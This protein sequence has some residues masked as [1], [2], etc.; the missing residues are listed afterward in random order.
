M[1]VALIGGAGF[2]GTRLAEVLEDAGTQFQ[3]LDKVLTGDR[4]I[5]ITD[6][7]TFKSKP[8]FDAVINLAAEHRDDVS[9]KSQYDLVNVEG[10][11]N[12][13]QFCRDRDIKTIVFTS[14]VAVYGFAPEG[15]KE[16]GEIN[17]FNDYGRTKYLAENVYRAWH[18]EDP[19]NRNLIIVRPTVIFGEGNR[20]NVYNLFNQI[21]SGRFL[22]FGN[23]RNR[24][25]MA[26]VQNVAEFL[27]FSTKMTGYHLYNYID[28]PNLDMNTLV[29]IVR[30]ILFG[31][32]E[33]G[34]RLP[35]WL[36]I[37]IG[38]TFDLVAVCLNRNLTVSSIR[39]KKFMG[40]TSFDSSIEITGFTSQITLEEGL[41][42]TL[43]Y[44]FIEDNSN[45][46]TFQSE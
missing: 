41:E 13:C 31:K 17:Y 8:A 6:P 21:A 12:I 27:N 14:T 3:I 28:K 43:T 24:K 45:K 42:R 11:R 22:V 26:Y 36:G 44:E 2:V 38:Y 4:Y 34:L 35:G 23:G 18:Q 39:V 46:R 9:P 1:T 33:I 5:D 20:G 30:Q 40:T 10:S 19:E 29:R 15:T 16:D 32:S 7:E 25:S 37:L